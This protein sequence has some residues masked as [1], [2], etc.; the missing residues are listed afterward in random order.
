M[1]NILKAIQN[2]VSL[3]RNDLMQIYSG[4]NRINNTGSTLEYYLKD[5]FCGTFNLQTTA[6]KDSAYSQYLSYVGNQNNPPDFI[7]LGGDAV[8]VKKIEGMNSDIA[9]NSSYPKAKIYSNSQ[10]ITR[11]CRVCEG[12]GA[13]DVKDIIYAVGTVVRRSIKCLWMVYGDCYAAS[14]SIYE[15][16]KN[17]ISVDI[18]GMP[19]INFSPTNELARVNEVDPLGITYLRLR[20]V[21]GIANPAS[22]FEYVASV[23]RSKSF[24]L[25]V[26]MKIEKYDGFPATDRRCIEELSGDGVSIADIEIQDPDN[27]VRF[28]NA[29]L[30]RFEI[31]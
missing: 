10:M 24:S 30:I 1:T 20:G 5:I 27:P 12:D 7:I 6:E 29:K 17:R 2:L 4:P 14:N 15:N 9:L 25:I 22:V 23:D 3:R 19:G 28:L 8:E 18:N 13:W 16:L 31:D 21:W 26:I 11:A